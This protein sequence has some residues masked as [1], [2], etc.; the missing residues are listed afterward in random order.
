MGKVKAYQVLEH[1]TA[2]SQ[3]NLFVVLWSVQVSSL[4]KQWTFGDATT[5]FPAK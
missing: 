4:R 5:G 3:D 2:I 1:S